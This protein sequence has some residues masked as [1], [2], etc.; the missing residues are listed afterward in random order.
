[1]KKTLKLSNRIE[2]LKISIASPEDVESW[3]HGEITKPETINYRTQQAE[4]EG[5]FCP[6]IFGPEQD[7]QCSC[8]KF[9][10]VQYHGIICDK[11]GVEITKSAIRRERMGHINLA[12]PVA[13]PWFLKK[14]PSKMSALLGMPASQLTS[15]IYYSAY[16]ITEVNEDVRKKYA[17]KIKDEVDKKIAAATRKETTN[18]LTSLYNER[19]AELAK[20]TV[21]SVINETDYYELTAQFPGLFVGEKGSEPI[22]R[23]LKALSLPKLERSVVKAIETA[24]AS[25]VEKLN[26]QLKLIRTLMQSGNK[27]E[28]M[29]LT[30]LPVIPPG[31]RP[32]VVI[33][34]G[35]YAS[36]DLN[37]LYRKVIM[38]N[39]RLKDL[40]DTKS[41]NI[42][43]N[44]QKR[45]VQEAVD[46]LVDG[47]STAGQ[48]YGKGQ[49]RT[50]KSISEFIGGKEGYFR[51]NLL[52]KRVNYS[53]RSVIVNGAYLKMNECGFPKEMALEIF[54]PFIVGDLLNRE[55]ASNTR[56][57]QRL[58]DDKDNIVWE[59]LERVIEGKYIILNR[60]PTLHRL[61]MLAFKP[62]LIEGKAI[63]LHPLVC[64]GYNADFDGDQ[65]AVHLPLSEEAQAEARE[66]LVSAKNIIKPGSGE[67]ISSP[68]QQ[69]MILGCYWAT[70][71][72]DGQKGEGKAFG[73]VSEVITAY[74]HGIIDL[75]AKIKVKPSDKARY[76]AFGGN[77]FDTTV[78]RVL[79]NNLLPSEYPYVNEEISKPKLEQIIEDIVELE[80]TE[81]AV[82][83]FD[84]IKDFGFDYSTRSGVT[85]SWDDLVEPTGK[86]KMITTAKAKVEET[87]E[88]YEN[89]L[90]SA[91]ERGRRNVETWQNVKNEINDVVR[92]EISEE[93]SIGYMIKSGAR[94]SFSHLGDMVGIFGIVDSVKDEPIETAITSS[95]KNGLKPIEY[96]ITSFG[97]RKG[98]S[99]TALK[100]A[101]AGYLSRKIASVASYVSVEGPN[102]KTKDG[103]KIFRHTV[104]GVSVPLGKRIRG[105]YLSE[106]IKEG[107]VDLKRDD[108]ITQELADKIEAEDKIVYV[109]LRSP[110]T[111]KYT[112]GV[113]AK[114]YGDDKSTGKIVDI[115]EPVGVIAAQS[116]AEPG[117]Q[118]TM[119]TFHTGGIAQA[120]GDITAGLPRVTELLE[121]R[122][123]KYPAVISRCDG[124]VEKI[125]DE[126]D[127]T[128]T[129][130][131]TPEKKTEKLS[132]RKLTV[133]TFRYLTIKE[134]DEI[135]KGQI[136]SDG[137]AD[138][139]ELLKYAGK[140]TTQEHIFGELNSV[141]EL[142]GQNL[143]PIHFE[144]I[145]A[146][147]FSRLIITDAGDSLY[148]EGEYIGYDKL[149]KVNTELNAAEKKPIVAEESITGISTVS[150]TKDNFLSS[151]AFQ[152]TVSVLINSSIRGAVDDLDGPKQ[153]IILGR[154]IPLGTG[155]EGS[156][157]WQMIQDVREEVQA[158]METEE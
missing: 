110:L 72:K 81:G 120:G 147:M 101:D 7:M 106:D 71:V 35:L 127:G 130:Y 76:A 99:D 112:K 29:F 16:M 55:I 121:R 18:M 23:K 40:M 158:S 52:A 137:S 129:V 68:I 153:N 43:I 21:D 64:S 63:E 94:G 83:Y 45:L 79:F 10:G 32:L 50:L 87:N 111:C 82:K 17:T 88:Q 143:S 11:C 136:L 22:Y 78:G 67:I 150:T 145:I 14:I 53:G 132:S 31:I 116:I 126:E 62:I 119:R 107:K 33:D 24:S 42:L 97:S 133:P 105:R 104:S 9:K 113:C 26:N 4:K 154:L 155:F 69:D 1:M 19:M 123:P 74:D 56:A 134:G 92:S 49:S 5:L 6:K 115:G 152:N 77:L 47:S 139:N 46:A 36:S 61:G 59:S 34:G 39:N 27:P 38:R 30:K 138:L 37:D 86:D 95:I 25:Q 65:M 84:N 60:Q 57:A 75:R 142:Q 117:T 140:S 54:K 108:Y 41:P 93:S 125:V 103:Y 12:T 91:R 70:V 109:K 144:I 114:C 58:I 149:D 66:I 8:G 48:T 51:S 102:C 141:Y 148:T 44:T 28:W 157:K 100:T 15:I 2:S 3:S 128:K 98:Q 135:K 151:A 90:I 124:I 20:V 118:L 122:I 131:V 156:K 146:Q 13:H 80:G 96:F 89:G 85:F 73:S